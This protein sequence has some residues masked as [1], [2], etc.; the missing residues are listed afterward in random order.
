MSFDD[1]P[2]QRI[3]LTSIGPV[4]WDR[5]SASAHA[6]V[7]GLST[8]ADLRV[9]SALCTRVFTSHALLRTRKDEWFNGVQAAQML[10]RLR[11]QPTPADIDSLWALLGKVFDR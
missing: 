10:A 5:A 8:A 3:Y 4:T 7:A 6:L 2:T 9:L 11:N 1:A